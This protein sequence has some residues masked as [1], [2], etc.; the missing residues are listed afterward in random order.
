M[1][2]LEEWASAL[3]KDSVKEATG[4]ESVEELEKAVW[5]REMALV[6]VVAV[7]AVAATGLGAARL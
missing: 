4:W 3:E 5:V 2:R 6:R 7:L 1:A